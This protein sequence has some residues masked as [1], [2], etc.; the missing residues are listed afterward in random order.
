MHPALIAL[1]D[2]LALESGRRHEVCLTYVTARGRWYAVSWKGSEDRSGGLVTNIGVH[3][4]DLLIWLFGPVQHSEVHL[5]TPSRAAGVLELPRA[6]VRWFLSSELSDVPADPSG[7]DTRMSHRSM[8][9][10]EQEINFTDG[11]VDLHTRLYE[12]VLAG[13]GFGID[14]A[15]P[16][17]EAAYRI[18]QGEVVTRFDICHPWVGAGLHS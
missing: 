6:V 15:R 11:F 3:L 10:D 2:R 7:E 9:V 12:E 5:R 17:I 4:F 8:T 14:E 16:G 13:R 1:R 18:R